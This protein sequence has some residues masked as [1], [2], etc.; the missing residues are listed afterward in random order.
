MIRSGFEVQ[1]AAVKA[2]F[3]EKFELGLVNFAWDIYGQF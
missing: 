3:L 2:L 1:V